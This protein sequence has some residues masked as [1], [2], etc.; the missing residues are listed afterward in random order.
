MSNK[1]AVMTTEEITLHVSPEAARAYQRA[2]PQERLKLETLVS[3]QLLDQ[4]RPRRSLDAI[5]EE[6]SRQAQERG[7]TPEALEELLRGDA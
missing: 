6:M 4:L 7:L 5:M 1:E 3:L 2:T